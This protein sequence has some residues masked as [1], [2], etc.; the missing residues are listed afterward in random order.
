[1]ENGLEISWRKMPSDLIYHPLANNIKTISLKSY[2]ATPY[3][4]S[5]I[6]LS[7]NMES[8]QT[9]I[10]RCWAKEDV[11]YIFNGILLNHYKDE[12]EPL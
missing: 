1:M 8:A 3:L 9:L 7:L 10:N 2:L 12:I 6:S 4:Y 11:L 5:C